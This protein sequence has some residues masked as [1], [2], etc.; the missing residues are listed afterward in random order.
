MSNSNV[1]S[2]SNNLASSVKP[3]ANAGTP[4]H[5]VRTETGT[6]ADREKVQDNDSA[7][8]DQEIADVK[9]SIANNLQEEAA[10]NKAEFS[11]SDELEIAITALQD[12]VQSV[13]RDLSFRVDDNSGDV[14]VTVLDSSTQEVIRQIPREDAI[15]L[16][17]KVDDI[18]FNFVNDSA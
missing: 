12:H 11:E 13:S 7:T 8:I 2:G 14:V 16:S 10:D 18:G 6:I 5:K 3:A 4:E 17:R 9:V 15:E 1:L